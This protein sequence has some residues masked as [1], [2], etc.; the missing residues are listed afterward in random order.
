MRKLFEDKFTRNVGHEIDG[1][2]FQPVKEVRFFFFF[3]FVAHFAHVISD[4]NRRSSKIY[5]L[6]EGS[7]KFSERVVEISLVLY[8][9]CCIIC[10]KATFGDSFPH[11][12]SFFFE[13]LFFTKFYSSTL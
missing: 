2:I 4:E 8:Y 7:G 13:E 10:G 12:L 6:I 11:H 1:L 5:L 3:L 9:M